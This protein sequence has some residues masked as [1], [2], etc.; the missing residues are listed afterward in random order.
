[1]AETEDEAEKRALEFVHRFEPCF[2]GSQRFEQ[3]Y[4]VTTAGQA[5]AVTE[6]DVA[7]R[8]PFRY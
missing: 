6:G 1:M 3:G 7:P 2:E 4:V 5:L 8:R